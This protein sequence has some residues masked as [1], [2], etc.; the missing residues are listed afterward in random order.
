M[1]EWQGLVINK[2]PYNGC[3]YWGLAGDVGFKWREETRGVSNRIRFSLSPGR[4]PLLP[5][6]RDTLFTLNSW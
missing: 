6:K 5:G 4:L 2:S 3:M 1:G